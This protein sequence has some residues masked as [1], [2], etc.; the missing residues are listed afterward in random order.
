M[1]HAARQHIDRVGAR[2]EGEDGIAPTLVALELV[3]DPPMARLQVEPLLER[4][5]RELLLPPPEVGNAEIAEYVRIEE[6]PPHGLL[7]QL[8]SF[9]GA[10]VGECQGEA[11]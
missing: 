2:Q 3:P 5:E 7:A 10:A 9:L 11:Q 4:L 1:S 6:L 8:Q